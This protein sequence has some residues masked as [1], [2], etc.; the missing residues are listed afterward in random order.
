MGKL[1]VIKTKETSASVEGFINSVKNEEIRKDSFIILKMM[2]KAS[3]EKPKMW[4]N[5]IIGFGNKI[6]KSPATGREVE[7]FKIGFSP[8]KTNFSLH[9][10]LNIKKY[11]AELKKLGKHKTGVGCLYINKLGDVDLKV[12]EKLINTAAKIK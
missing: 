1:A 12:L 4:G 10:V 9:L 3:K 5:S 2:R 11:S 7:W 8:R 6:Y